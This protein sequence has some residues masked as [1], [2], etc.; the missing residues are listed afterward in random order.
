MAPHLLLPPLFHSSCILSRPAR[1]CQRHHCRCATLR[2]H[3]Q[4]MLP[5]RSNPGKGVWH[6]PQLDL[7][8]ASDLKKRRLHALQL[9]ASLE[10]TI[11]P[12]EG[13][14]VGLVRAELARQAS[15]KERGAERVATPRVRASAC[16]PSGQRRR[17]EGRRCRT[18]RSVSQNRSPDR[19]VGVRRR[20]QGQSTEQQERR[21]GSN[22]TPLALAEH[23]G[24]ERRR[25]EGSCGW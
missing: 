15:S 13:S 24:Q 23:W 1:A 9:D 11:Y 17:T 21:D 19:G 25:V 10:S 16:I 7:F 14:S 3:H 22:P 8:R 5:R 12:Y 2:S 6:S 4:L 20:E 18:I